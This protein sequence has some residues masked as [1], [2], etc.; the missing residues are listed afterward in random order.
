MRYDE[1]FKIEIM[2]ARSA[3]VKTFSRFCHGDNDH[4]CI[5]KKIGKF[6]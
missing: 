5:W 2:Y 4:D 1:L 6:I 3:V